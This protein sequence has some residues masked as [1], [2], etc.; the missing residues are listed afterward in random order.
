MDNIKCDGATLES[1][2]N[3]VEF[4][5]DFCEKCQETLDD[6]LDGKCSVCGGNPCYNWG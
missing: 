3:Q 6:A 2:E 1:C 5:G 4:A